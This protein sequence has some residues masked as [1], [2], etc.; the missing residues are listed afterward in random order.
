MWNVL[1]VARDVF[2]DT[3]SYTDT[4]KPQSEVRAASSGS[5]GAGEGLFPSDPEASSTNQLAHSAWDL[6]SYFLGQR[7]CRACSN[8]RTEVYLTMG[9]WVPEQPD[10]QKFCPEVRGG[11][12]E[13]DRSGGDR[14]GTVL[15]EGVACKLPPLSQLLRPLHVSLAPRV[16]PATPESFS[17]N[18]AFSRSCSSVAIPG[19]ALTD[20]VCTSVPSSTRKVARAQPPQDPSTWSRTPGA[21]HAHLP[22]PP[23]SPKSSKF[24]SVE[25]PTRRNISLP[26][27]KSQEV[28]FILAPSLLSL[29]YVC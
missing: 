20:A 25:Q 15:K 9:R 6:P 14:E 13:W 1:P 2:S 12:E 4:C 19:T 27:G 28:P 26:I 10:E 8:V 24:P 3:T 7:H 17:L 18:H 5:G 16:N 23:K 21:Q 11:G 29:A 22:P